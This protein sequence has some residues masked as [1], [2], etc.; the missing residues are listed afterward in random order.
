MKIAL[1]I[2]LKFEKISNLYMQATRRLKVLNETHDIK[3]DIYYAS[4]LPDDFVER[5]NLYDAV[6]TRHS[7]PLNIID[8]IKVPI[9]VQHEVPYKT[10]SILNSKLIYLTDKSYIKY[11]PNAEEQ[12][13]FAKYSYGKKLQDRKYDVLFMGRYA[14]N[15]NEY[16]LNKYKTNIIQFVLYKFYSLNMKKNVNNFLTS[17]KLISLIKGIG[18]CKIFFKDVFV[19]YWRLIH[20]IRN[21]RR[22]II[23]KQLL[24]LADNGYKVCLVIDKS[25]R[26]RIKKH[27]NIDFFYDKNLIEIEKLMSNSKTTVVQTNTVNSIYDERFISSLYTGSIPL[28]EPYPQYK[29]FF[30][31]FYLNFFFDFTKDSLYSAVK[32]VII[33][34][35]KYN[36]SK[37]LINKNCNAQLSEY[38]FKNIFKK[39]L[40]SHTIFR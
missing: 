20:S 21:T 22:E 39:Y 5:I 28:T 33:N 4:N 13:N 11:C 25:S 26:H 16:G 9:F 29:K 15:K 19:F 14:K 3:K 40:K 27:K 12:I 30:K 32:N 7:F 1:F 37:K 2:D 17:E 36:K 6:Y 24:K 8:K 18:I 23:I 10:M 34:L 38:K 31:S 35:E